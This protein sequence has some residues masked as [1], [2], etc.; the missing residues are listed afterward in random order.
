MSC[1]SSGTGIGLTAETVNRH[2]QESHQQALNMFLR[3]YNTKPEALLSDSLMPA[4]SSGLVVLANI[5]F[6]SLCEHHLVPFFGRAS[7][8]FLPHQKVV[9]LGKLVSTVEVLAQR[10]QFQ[11]RL[12]ESIADVVNG[13]L[14]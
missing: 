13:V 14:E 4:E 11:E 6:V 9:G 3:G 2:M 1:Q 12:T 5:P 10:L 8:A 7:I